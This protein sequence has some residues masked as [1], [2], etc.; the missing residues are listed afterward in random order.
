MNVI[1]HTAPLGYADDLAILEEGDEVGI[2]RL[3]D[4]V[5]TISIGSKKETDMN[6]NN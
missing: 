2:T 6:N 5:T 3:S 4:R 1:I